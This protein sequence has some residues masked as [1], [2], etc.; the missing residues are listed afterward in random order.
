MS[1]YLLDINVLV[2][3]M[4]T[5][6]E[7]H[8]AARDWYRLHQRAGWATCPM[9][10]AGFVRISSNPRVFPAAPSPSK[11]VEILK[12]NLNH[13]S[14]QFWKDDI[15]FGQAVAP[16]SNRLSGHQQTTDA[17]LFGLALHKRGVLATFDASIVSLVAGNSPLLKSIEILRV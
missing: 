6:H 14:H 17:Y 2:A 15:T 11:A 9:T 5:N 10:Q 8:E 7:Q 12:T 3:L 13:S 1:V 16:F 4:W